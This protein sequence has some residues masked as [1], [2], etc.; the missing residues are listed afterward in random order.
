[1]L[2]DI[3]VVATTSPCGAGKAQY[4]NW[5]PLASKTVYLWPDNDTN[6]QKHMD[7][8]EQQLLSLNPTPEIC[9]VDVEKLDLLTKGDIEQYLD[10]LGEV[11]N[12]EKQQAVWDVL[13][14]SRPDKPSMRVMQR[15]TDTIDG[16]RRA[17]D[18]PWP[19]L[20]RMSKALLPGTITIIAG[21][22]ASAKSLFMLESLAYLYENNIKAVILELEEDLEFHL[23][24]ALVQLKGNSDL[25]NDEWVRDNPKLTL[26]QYYGQE[27]FLDGF[28]KCIHE[29]PQQMMTLFEIK[30]W[31]AAAA[32]QGNRVIVVDPITIAEK[33]TNQPWNEDKRFMA[34]IGKIAVDHKVSI[35]LVT[36]PK[37]G[38]NGLIDLEQVSGG[39]AY[40]LFSQTVIWIENHNPPKFVSIDSPCGTMDNIK[41]N[42]T[43]YILKARNARG[44]GLKLGYNLDGESLRFAEQGIIKE[45]A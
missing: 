25:L 38:R 7:E 10:G 26:E 5:E 20:S 37:K 21:P 39:Q 15:V 27:G 18:W 31:I 29:R 44:I 24:R 16:K 34:D 6:G 42:R 9:R 8:V 45:K 33:V 41:I 3:G 12:S 40:S 11:A 1:M 17:I 35:V 2:H 43:V 4:A 28:G 30:E 13:E 23:N 32:S 19:A 36:H 22:P 14:D